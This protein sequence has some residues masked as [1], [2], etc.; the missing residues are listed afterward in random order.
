MLLCALAVRTAP[1]APWHVLSRF[2]L[3]M[4]CVLCLECAPLPLYLAS[5]SS[6]SS[7]S[8]P[9]S[10]VSPL[11]SLPCALQAEQPLHCA[12]LAL[13]CCLWLFVR[14]STLWAPRGQ[15][16]CLFVDSVCVVQNLAHGRYLIHVCFMFIWLNIYLIPEVHSGHK[17]LLNKLI[18]C[19]FFLEMPFIVIGFWRYSISL[20]EKD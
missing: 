4:C 13:C 9:S 12:S 3:L 7:S 10:I 6:S 8:W 15:G 16:P 20:R 18:Y 1:P 17:C 5:S 11:W 19:T 2:C 14:V